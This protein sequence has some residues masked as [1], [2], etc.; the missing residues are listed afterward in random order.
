[1]MKGRFC[2]MDRMNKRV[3]QQIATLLYK[4]IIERINNLVSE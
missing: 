4:Q 1:M 3:D 2:I